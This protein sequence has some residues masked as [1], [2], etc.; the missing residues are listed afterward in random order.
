MENYTYETV[1]YDTFL[2][3]GFTDSLRTT[4]SQASYETPQISGT[5][6]SSGLSSSSDGKF[7]VDWSQSV[8]VVTDGARNRIEMGKIPGTDLYGI[9]IYDSDG[10]II[11]EGGTF[12]LEDDSITS[13]MISGLSAS[14]ILT[15]TLRADT[16]I[17]VGDASIIIS[18]TNRN[19][20]INDGDNDRVK[21]G[22]LG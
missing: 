15:G 20:I 1:G 5:A 19:I 22:F 9:R 4:E 2:R 18:G 10:E 21:I 14:K 13:S 3:R 17:S 11:F 8:L 7:T 6:I 16:E 12:V